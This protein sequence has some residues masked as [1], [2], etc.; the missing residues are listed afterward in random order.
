MKYDLIIR[1]EAEL[2]MQ[3]A[4]GWYEE[5]VSGLGREFLRCVDAAI[6]QI[7]RS[8]QT[9]PVIYQNVHRILTR[10]FPFGIFYIIAGRRIIVLAVLHARRDPSL[11]QKR[12]FNT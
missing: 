11:W 10:R 12:K 3:G 7:N 5:R 9:H 6:A 4:F 1:P 8:P 2:D